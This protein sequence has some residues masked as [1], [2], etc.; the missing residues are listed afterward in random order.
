MHAIKL[1]TTYDLDCREVLFP[2]TAWGIGKLEN[3]EPD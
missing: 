3:I 1:F 2:M